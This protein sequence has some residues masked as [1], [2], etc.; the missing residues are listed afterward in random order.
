MSTR[1]KHMYRLSRLDTLHEADARL[2]TLREMEFKEICHAIQQLE[3]MLSCAMI[4]VSFC[5]LRCNI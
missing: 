5:M 3:S 1:L 2:D 4:D